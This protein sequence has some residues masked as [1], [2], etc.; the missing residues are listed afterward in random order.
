[1][2]AAAKNLALTCGDSYFRFG[3][4]VLGKL[5]RD[6]EAQIVGVIDNK[7]VECVHKMRVSTRKIRAVMPLFRSCY[8][9]KKYKHWLNEIKKVTKLLSEA[10]DLDVQISFLQNYIQKSP[11]NQALAP[12][13]KDH[14]DQRKIVQTA[15]IEGLENLKGS[16]VLTEFSVFL[17]QNANDLSIVPFD[18]LSVL[19]KSCWNMTCM[20]DDLLALSCFVH[21]ESAVLKHHEMRINAK[22]LRYTMETFAPLYKTGLKQEIKQ[23]KDFQDLLGEMH[24]CDVWLAYLSTF[25]DSPKKQK[26]HV[27]FPELQKALTEFSTYIRFYKKSHYDSFVKLWDEALEQDFFGNLRKTAH[28]E[29]SFESKKLA[30]LLSNPNVKVAVVSDIHANLHA[31]E[32]VVG[33][34]EK[35]GATVFLNAGDSVGY[36]AYPTEVIKLL[37][38]KNV[39][40]VIG[41]FDSAVFKN[42][43]KNVGAKKVAVD[44]VNEDLSKTCKAYLRS[45]PEEVKLDIA[46][47]QLLMTHASPKSPTEHITNKTPDA[48][49]KKILAD[50][51]AN[52]IIVGHSHE[53]FQRQIDGVSFVNPGSVG[54]PGDGNSQTA[55]ALLS[56]NPFN[57]ELVRLDYPFEEAAGALR[58]K[59]LPESF[60]QMLLS[61]KA[62]E[63]I[64]GE[65]KAKKA[66][67]QRDWTQVIQ[68]ALDLSKSY[69]Q[70]TA[71]VEHVRILAL[72]LFDNLQSLHQMGDNERRLLECAALLH[73]LGLSKGVK[74]HNKASMVIILNE[75]RLSLTSEERRVV[76]SIARYHRKAFPKQKHYNLFT[77]NRKTV[78]IITALS[79]I[80]RIAD[81]LD[82]LHGSDVKLVSVKV[83]TKNVTVECTCPSDTSLVEQAFDKKKDLFEK[84]FKKKVVLTWN[85][86]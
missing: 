35:R 67:P 21:Q 22:R 42:S 74:G 38:E 37:Y 66:D 53:Q 84:F 39:V 65:D 19:E 32:T 78:D 45:L 71:H 59:G 33:D 70:D 46:G 64:D 7:D 3:C 79:S 34:A 44:Y 83:A 49:L 28:A 41:N 85:K 6:F 1:M 20:L 47:K 50:V 30:V 25:I 43:S 27:K 72:G 15:V 82:Y 24:D 11:E 4:D 61:G 23:L 8:P 57:V 5:L 76:A 62:I 36:G 51:D 48:R 2:S 31:F 80:L 60:S 73:D 29:A 18:A 69:L 58:K 56:F 40:S 52:V 13:L 63:A 10:R 14:K 12:I 77:L 68:A 16:G 26:S 86:R 75:A 54:R 9:K 17:K 55:Y 81:A